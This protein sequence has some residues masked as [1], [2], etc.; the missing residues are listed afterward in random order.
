MPR[1]Q[2]QSNQSNQSNGQLSFIEELD[3]QL[4]KKQGELL[5]LPLRTDDI[6]AA[7]IAILSKGLYTDPLDCIREYVQNAVDAGAKETTIKITSNSVTIFDKGS[8][9]DLDALVQARQFGLS[10][11]SLSDFVGFRGIGIYSGFDLCRR[12]RITTTKAG[13]PFL[14][15]MVFEFAAMKAQLEKDKQKKPGETRTSLSELLSNHTYIKRDGNAPADLHF[16][17]VELQDISD[18]HIRHLSDRVELKR[19]LLKNLPIDFS[20]DFEHKQEINNHLYAYVRG[21]NAVKITIQHDGLPDEIVVKDAIPNLQRPTFGYI[22]SG[23]QKVGYY[24]A[25]LR[26]GRRKI[27]LANRGDKDKNASKE[28]VLDY[29][30]YEGFVYKVKGFTIG[31]RQRLRSKFSR[32]PQL[33]AWYTGEIYVTD[34]NI[35]PNAARDDFE[36]S[37]SSR[38]LDLAVGNKLGDLE[39]IVEQYQAQGVADDRIEEYKDEFERIDE[40]VRTNTQRDDYEIYARLSEI[41]KDIRRQK[42]KS[43][44]ENRVIADDIIKRSTRLQDQLKKEVEK[45]TSEARR[46]TKAARSEQAVPRTPVP[47]IEPPPP[48]PIKTLEGIIQDA[49]LD[50]EGS[51]G[52]VIRLLQESV[53]DV[54]GSGSLTYKNVLND[55]EAR[56]ISSLND[57]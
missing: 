3:Q 15:V 16:T 43:S 30:N 13:D 38:L 44:P 56:L 10:L 52:L 53:S 47:I 27:S 11:K 18:V 8:G 2:Q 23:D 1:R 49:G 45:P 29:K 25:C 37:P 35:I 6:G 21:Y 57:E 14:H 50:L 39:D 17:T 7:L 19:Y 33:Y 31:D 40:Q 9:M 36:T 51:L 5:L 34:D 55:F 20:D 4:S 48:V 42:T 46:R 41:L 22:E 24:W 32:K 54:L 26:K 12:L 28:P